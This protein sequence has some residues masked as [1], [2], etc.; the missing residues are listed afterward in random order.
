M[1]PR[2]PTRP[3]PWPPCARPTPVP[4]RC[5]SSGMKNTGM[6]GGA[7]GCEAVRSMWTPQTSSSWRCARCS[8]PTTCTWCGPTP[9]PRLPLSAWRRGGPG[10]EDMATH[11]LDFERPLLELERQIDELKR[12]ATETAGDATKGPA[13]LEK[14]LA[15]LRAEVYKNLTPLPPV[16]GARPPHRPCNLAYLRPRVQQ[17]V[18]LALD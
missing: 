13:P 14:R 1:R 4:P 12:V 18:L 10:R 8:A 3:A 9:V 6:A 17:L 2:R 11:T 16:Q 5:W 7:S 15:E